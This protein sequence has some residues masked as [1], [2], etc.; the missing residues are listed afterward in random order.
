MKETIPTILLTLTLLIN[1]CASTP[2]VTEAA[3]PPIVEE[4]VEKTAAQPPAA[5]QESGQS[6]S[7]VLN[8]DYE[9]AVPVA[10]QL[11]LGTFKLEGTANAVTKEQAAALTP[12]WTNFKS[13]SESMKPA[14]GEPGQGQQGQPNATPQ[15]VDSGLQIQLD[16]IIQQIQSTMTVEQ[17]QAIADM[18]ITQE[19]SRTIMEQ[20]VITMG[21]PQQGNGGMPGGGGQSPADGNM[22]QGTPPA[23]G[24]GGGQQP[25]AN[26]MSTP[27]AG[28]M[29]PDGMGFIPSELIDAFLKLLSEKS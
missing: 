12:L 15:P 26:Q 18:K 6:E 21:G 16:E 4:V 19:T 2:P 10:M 5:L 28:G 20:Q 25:G 11:L 29:Q 1:A 13:L 27:P 3:A 22:P 14:Q 8:A 9:N 7:D 23:G 24:P 17:I